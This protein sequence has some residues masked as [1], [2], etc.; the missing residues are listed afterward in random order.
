M[1]N[2]FMRIQKIGKLVLTY[3]EELFVFSL[4]TMFIYMELQLSYTV[5]TSST[6]HFFSLSLFIEGFMYLFPDIA[7]GTLL[8]A[9]FYLI[10]HEHTFWEAF[11][12]YFILC[13][14]VWL[15]I[16]PL[17]L[18]HFPGYQTVVL[19]KD[20]ADPLVSQILVIPTVFRFLT[21]R[22]TVIHQIGFLIAEQ[23]Y[24]RM[25]ILLPFGIAVSSLAGLSKFSSWRLINCFVVILLFILIVVS[26][27]FL[28]DPVFINAHELLTS[29]GY[30]GQFIFNAVL[31]VLFIAADIICT[32]I[33]HGNPNREI[34]L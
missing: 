11:I 31:S 23:G 21:E 25:I 1:Y 33:R 7:I 16:V 14:L 9:I 19:F 3:M 5:N 34:L 8:C 27:S 28:I 29:L 30:W 2:F 24:F 20:F 6:G 4:V 32:Y 12:G 26:N 17:W 13:A 15:V 10:R 22:C 18:V